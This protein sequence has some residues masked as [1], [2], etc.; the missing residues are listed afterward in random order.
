[1]EEGN[2]IKHTHMIKIN[3]KNEQ[4]KTDI[5]KKT[6]ALHILIQIPNSL[7]YIKKYK[8]FSTVGAK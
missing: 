2:I 5:H 7:F 8:T 4:R 3:N 1:M 6:S